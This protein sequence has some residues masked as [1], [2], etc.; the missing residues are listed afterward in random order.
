[1]PLSG[2]YQLLPSTIR[3]ARSGNFGLLNKNP[4]CCAKTVAAIQMSCSYGEN[5]NLANAERLVREA[6]GRGA[7]V[8][9]LQELFSTRLFGMQD[10]DPDIELCAA[11][12]ATRNRFA[13]NLRNFILSSPQVNRHQKSGKD[14]GE[15]VPDRNRWWFAGRVLEVKRSTGSLWTGATQRRPRSRRRQS[16]WQDHVQGGAAT[17]GTESSA[18]SAEIHSRSPYPR[19]ASSALDPPD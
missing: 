19:K 14:A 13:Q 12:R 18:S 16:Q 17:T 6:A 7:N 4:A 1:M 8:M 15:W 11:D 5:E 10:W 3:I 9:L 2:W